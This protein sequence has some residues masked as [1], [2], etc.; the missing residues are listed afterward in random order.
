MPL[1]RLA[2]ALACFLWLP[3]LLLGQTPDE[4]WRPGSDDYATTQWCPPGCDS[5]PGGGVGIGVIGPRGGAAGVGVYRPPQQPRQQPAPAPRTQHPACLVL[6][7]GGYVGVLIV[8]RGDT[9]DI[10]TCAHG[11]NGKTQSVRTSDGQQAPSTVVWIDRRRDAALLTAQL[12]APQLMKVAA[13]VPQVGD[14][15][16]YGGCGGGRWGFRWGKLLSINPDG[17]MEISGPSTP[18]DSGGPIYNAADE[19]VGVLSGTTGRTTIAACWQL[20]IAGRSQTPAPPPMAGP[21]ASIPI[22]APPDPEITSL[23]ERVGKL[24]TELAGL[25]LTPVIPGP[26]GPQGPPGRDGAMGPAGPPG[27][28]A[29]VDTQALAVAISKAL[30]PIRLQTLNPDGTVHQQ[31]DARLGDLVRIKPIIV[32][33][34]AGGK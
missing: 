15:L 33:N 28:P 20:A 32:T 31:A 17:L 29:T 2:I 34:K 24:E 18:G 19:L 13:T 26:P 9:V 12:K 14:M 27:A 25:R 16:Q 23:K 5:C 3:G 10:A 7:D 11:P 6:I 22:P 21:P 1:R 8:Q 4:G 30:P